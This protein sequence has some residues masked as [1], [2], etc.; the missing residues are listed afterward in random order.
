MSARYIYKKKLVLTGG[1][2]P[3]TELWRLPINPTAVRPAESTVD[4]LGLKLMPHQT[5]VHGATKQCATIDNI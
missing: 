4:I 2:D 3:V 5:V 1:R